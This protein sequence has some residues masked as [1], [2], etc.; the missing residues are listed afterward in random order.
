MHSCSMRCRPFAANNLRPMGATGIGR[1]GAKY[2]A[3]ENG[4]N[5]AMPRPP[6][7]RVSS[8]PWL[9]I[10]TAAVSPR[11]LR[12]RS[13]DQAMSPSRSPHSAAKASE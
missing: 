5:S 4:R 10:T 2:L 7:V 6:S 8:S 9:A 1:Q 3:S 13:I 12:G 11:R